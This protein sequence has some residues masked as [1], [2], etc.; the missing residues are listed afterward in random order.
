M[1]VGKQCNGSDC[2]VLAIAFAYDICSGNDL[3]RVKFDDR[4][5]R[6]HLA[7]CLENCRL[8][9]FPVTGERR[10][11]GV[12]NTQVEDLHCSCRLPEVKGDKMAECNV[13]ETWYHQHCMDIPNEVFGDRDVP[14]TCTEC[15]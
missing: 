4:S 3:C 9:R 13:C 15:C 7:N 2:G 6:H 10:S 14:W 11:V 5:I 8:S 12:K 1:D